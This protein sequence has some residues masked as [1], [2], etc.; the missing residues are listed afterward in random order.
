[1]QYHRR[2][3]RRIIVKIT[4]KGALWRKRKNRRLPHPARPLPFLQRGDAMDGQLLD[5]D[6]MM[7]PESG[8]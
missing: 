5:G 7:W 8:P 2:F 4:V 1:M 6:V 3:L